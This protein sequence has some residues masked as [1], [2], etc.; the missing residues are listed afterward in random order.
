LCA[1]VGHTS[2]YYCYE[3][4]I[5]VICLVILSA[6]LSCNSTS[7]T[8][9]C[10]KFK[11]GDFYLKLKL[12]SSIISIKR[13]D[14]LQVE[15]N[16]ATGETITSKIKWTGPCELE[17]LFLS[18]SKDSPDSIIKFLQGK[19]VKSRIIKTGKNYYVFESKTD[20]INFTYTDTMWLGKP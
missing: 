12:D 13:N 8:Q 11:N 20:N 1:I 5:N 18:Q 15:T 17:M 3:I 4:S 9:D 7:Q 10:D 6:T 19:P 2:K 14:S 16:V